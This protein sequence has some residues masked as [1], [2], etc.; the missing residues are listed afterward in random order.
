[1]RRAA[2][3]TLAVIIGLAAISPATAQRSTAAATSPQQVANAMVAA[4]PPSTGNPAQRMSD[5]PPDQFGA[6]MNQWGEAV[7]KATG[8]D[9][10]LALFQILTRIDE[11][12]PAGKFDPAQ[13]TRLSQRL[14]GIP[15]PALDA[16][17]AATSRFDTKPS[18]LNTA[19]WMSRD[20][21]LF[22]ASNAFVAAS[23]ETQLRR[24]Q[25][26]PVP[27]VESWAKARGADKVPAAFTLIRVDQL[28]N[29]AN[30]FQAALFSQA[31]PLAEAQF[32]K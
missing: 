28:F 1:M 14:S 21:K 17:T 7:T 24:L 3:V 12:Y 13:S 16:W 4:A 26:V 9:P 6:A 10:G 19:V 30:V 2:T 29:S 31:L 20:P 32:K 25:N 11:L 23:A 8:D 27:A 5:T 22:N 18:K 15:G